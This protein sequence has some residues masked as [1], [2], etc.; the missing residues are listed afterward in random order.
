MINGDP[1]AVLGMY[2]ILQALAPA[3]ISE[4]QLK[5]QLRKEYGVDI[6]LL[7]D[8]FRR[9]K[10]MA[11]PGEEGWRIVK[12]LVSK[13][14]MHRIA[15]KSFSSTD[16]TKE[17][18]RKEV[19][20]RSAEHGLPP[21]DLELKMITHPDVENSYPPIDAT[22]EL[23]RKEMTHLNVEPSHPPADMTVTRESVEHS[24]PPAD[25][26]LKV[27]THQ[28]VEE[29]HPPTGIFY[30]LVALSVI[31]LVPDLLSVLTG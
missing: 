6:D 13:K 21:A 9:D 16:T 3:S 27:V 7:G 31:S 17:L 2:G 24:Y 18:A 20:H 10:K 29:S 30:L 11:S 15:E 25:L 14:L 19:T 5:T 1:A 4:D 28:N 22:K 26:E 12:E 8:D 23:V